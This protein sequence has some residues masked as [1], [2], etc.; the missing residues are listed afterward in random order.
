MVTGLGV[1]TPIGRC[2]YFLESLK[3]ERAVEVITSFDTSVLIRV[4][5]LKSKVLIDFAGISVKDARRMEV[6]TVSL[7]SAKQAITMPIRFR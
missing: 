6:C 1:I 3:S 5:L 7:A 4:L 2:F